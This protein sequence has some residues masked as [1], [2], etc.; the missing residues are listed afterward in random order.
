MSN[1]T[2]NPRDFIRSQEIPKKVVKEE[3]VSE[4]DPVTQEET[5]KTIRRV[6]LA[7]SEDAY[8]KLYY[9]NIVALTNLDGKVPATVL[10]AFA[11]EIQF[12]NDPDEPP[13]FNY[14]K[15]TKLRIMARTHLSE[16]QVNTYKKRLV[17]CGF[18]ITA[19]C[20][21]AYIANPLFIA[22]GEWDKIKD[23]RAEIDFVNGMY[24]YKK[25]YKA[26]DQAQQ[27]TEEPKENP[28]P[29]DLQQVAN[30]A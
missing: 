25:V 3:I 23:L 2:I 10:M 26:P 9:N 14:N 22:K 15:I 28:L 16:S 30:D 27:P 29:D 7:K 11:N 13:V 4:V 1:I 24:V 21:G 6:I 18:L 19:G 12:V 5:I 17:E 8:I 20:R